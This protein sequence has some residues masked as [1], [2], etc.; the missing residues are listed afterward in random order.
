MAL[1]KRQAAVEATTVRIATSDKSPS[2][3]KPRLVEYLLY[4]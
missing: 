3:N 1:V 2:F 4:I